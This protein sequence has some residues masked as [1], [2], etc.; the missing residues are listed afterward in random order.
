MLL[1]SKINKYVDVNVTNN[2]NKGTLYGAMQQMLYSDY[3]QVSRGYKVE[4]YMNMLF[5]KHGKSVDRYK[6]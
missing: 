5:E 6:A 4:T 2:K 1:D 3:W